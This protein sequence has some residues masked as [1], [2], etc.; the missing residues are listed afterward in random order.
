M[1]MKFGRFTII[2]EKLILMEMLLLLGDF[3]GAQMIK[4]TQHHLTYLLFNHGLEGNIFLSDLGTYR[5][6]ALETSHNWVL[7]VS[8]EVI[9]ESNICEF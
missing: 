9:M 3:Q 4:L 6:I 1:E 8:G 7:L 2:Y 5:K